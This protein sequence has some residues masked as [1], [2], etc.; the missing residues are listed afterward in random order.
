MKVL[1]TGGAGFIGSH[2]VDALLETGSDVIVV[3]DMSTGFERNVNREVRLYRTN[4]CD[5]ELSAIFERERPDM[6]CHQAA[7]TVVTRSIDDPLFDA[8]VNVLGSLNVLRNCKRAG[9]RRIVYASSCAV[10]GDVKYL[11]VDED[12]PIIPMSPY[13][14]SKHTV[15]HYLHLY[16]LVHNLSFMALRYANVYGPRQNE[17]AEAGVVAIFAGKMLSGQRP[18]IYGTGT[19]T[20]DY[21]YVQDVVTANLLALKSSE[22]GIC[23]IGTGTQTTD[24]MVFDTMSRLSGYAGPV[25]YAPER[26]GEI[27][28]MY[29]DCARAKRQLNWSPEISLQEGIMRAMEFYANTRE[30]RALHPVNVELRV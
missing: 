14:V 30:R 25:E 2:I 24:Q 22:T 9:V 4:I 6:V 27:R 15:E 12:H 13:G 1:V 21:V 11:P 29:L 20:R 23:N 3:D 18:T 19:K 17:R 5:P 28:R 10:Y 8:E 16:S 7:Q 26:P